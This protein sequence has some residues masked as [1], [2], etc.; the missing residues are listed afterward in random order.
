MRLLSVEKGLHFEITFEVESDHRRD[1]S[2]SSLF[3]SF[4][5]IAFIS[6]L[7]LRPP[8]SSFSSLSSLFVPASS[9]ADCSLLSLF[10][11]SLSSFSPLMHAR[12]KLQPGSQNRPRATFLPVLPWRAKPRTIFWPIR[13]G[14][15][16]EGEMWPAFSAANCHPVSSTSVKS[17]CYA[18]LYGPL[19][20]S[21]DRD[22][23]R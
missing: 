14:E 6:L 19:D 17:T 9:S 10:S 8:S 23:A 2:R 21:S 3:L 20:R 22:G 7:L 12:R 15:I 1:I 5:G 18:R 16:V 4:T 11:L 13:E